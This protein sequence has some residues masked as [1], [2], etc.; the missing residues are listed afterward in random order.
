[1][2]IE[3]SLAALKIISYDQYINQHRYQYY[4]NS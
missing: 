1:M 3:H 4:K 2:Q